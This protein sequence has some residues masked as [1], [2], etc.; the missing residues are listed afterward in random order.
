MVDTSPQ[1]DRW[2]SGCGGGG[3][4]VRSTMCLLLIGCCSRYRVP[5][6]VHTSNAPG[7]PYWNLH[8]TDASFIIQVAPAHGGTIHLKLHIIIYLPLLWHVLSTINNELY[9]TCIS[10][11]EE[12]TIMKSRKK[13]QLCLLLMHCVF[14]HPY[15]LCLYLCNPYYC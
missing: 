13:R 6:I 12:A 11:P 9:D 5:T 4:G 2:L 10:N 8:P 14:M 15:I 7:R 1:I 3:N